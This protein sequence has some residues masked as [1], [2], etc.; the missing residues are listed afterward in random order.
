[1]QHAATAV[2][3]VIVMPFI[4]FLFIFY[5]LYYYV[6]SFFA[7]EDRG[8]RGEKIMRGVAS[9]KQKQQ[10]INF[11]SFTWQCVFIT[12]CKTFTYLFISGCSRHAGDWVVISISIISR[13]LIHIWHYILFQRFYAGVLLLI[14]RS[15]L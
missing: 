5:I 1:M 3:E 6:A 11:S 2:A 9:I 10:A 14:Y 4:V 12:I 7:I 13:H 15:I 8:E